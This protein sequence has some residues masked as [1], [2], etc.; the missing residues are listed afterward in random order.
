MA[1]EQTTKVEHVGVKKKK[2]SRWRNPA[3]LT[4]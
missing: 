1:E 4:Y 2:K 3:A